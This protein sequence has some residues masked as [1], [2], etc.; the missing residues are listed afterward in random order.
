MKKH[1]KILSFLFLTLLV[2]IVCI[3]RSYPIAKTEVKQESLALNLSTN[4]VNYV[5]SLAV[6]I[7]FSDSS[8]NTHHLDDEQSVENAYKIFNSDELFEMNSVNGIIKVPSFKKYYEKESYGNLIITTEIFP[9]ENGKVVSY[10]D[11]HPIGYYLEYNEANKIGYKD[12][13]ESL[14]RETELIN[15][16]TNYIATMVAS[17]SIKSA[18]LDIDNDGF[19]DAIS[20]IIEGQKNLPSAIKWRDLLWSHERD[21]AG[22]EASI[23]GKKVKSYT[24]LYANDYT[25]SASL[26]SLNR[27]TY[28]TIIHEFGH[29]LGY[30]DLYRYGNDTAKPVGFYDIMGTTVGSNPQHFLTYY[31]SE[32]NPATNWH[33]PLPVIKETTNNITLYKPTFTDKTEK[34]AIKIQIDGIN[35]EYFVVEYHEKQNTY[36][37]HSADKSG[38]IVYRVNEKYKYYG[39]TDGSNSGAKDH[40]YIFRPNE[41]GLGDGKGDLREATLNMS[42]KTF[43][44]ELDLNNLTFDN[45]AIFFS[46]GTNSGI[47]IEVISE[48]SNSVTFNVEFPK[49][50]GSGT[51][52][53][54]YLIEDANTFMY[55]MKLSTKN[56]YYKLMKDIDFN[57]IENYPTINFEGNLEGN[58]KTLR[59]IKASN[60]VFKT[61]GYY[62]T[63]TTI[64]NLNIENIVIE[65]KQGDYLGGLAA[66]AENVTLNNV[67][68]KSGTIKQLGTL[69]HDMASTGGF[70]GNVNN[71]TIIKNCSAIADINAPK[72]IGGFIGLNMNAKIENS[73]ASSTINGTA[74]IGGFIGV[75]AIL[76]NKYNVPNN[77][78]YKAN[79]S[80]TLN[81]VG[82]Y[83]N[84][85]HN[86]NVLNE[87]SLA[88]GII[89][90]YLPERI[91]LATTEK[92]DIPFKTNPDTSLNYTAT[93]KD[94]NIARFENN[95]IIGVNKGNTD[96]YI[97][98]KIGA[99]MMQ[100]TSNLIV[101]DINKA[102]TEAEVL[103]ALGLNKKEQYVFGFNPG[104]SL[105]DINSKIKNI[106][107]VEL[108]GFTNENGVAIISGIAKTGIKLSL[109]INGT[110]YTYTIVILGDINGDGMIYATDYVKVKNHIMGKGTLTGAYLLA[111]DINKD[112]KIYATD[113]VQ[114]KNHIMGKTII[115]QQ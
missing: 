97:N 92:K 80:D 7:K 30:M 36:E 107:N 33:S 40:V 37:T 114:I 32:Y 3:Q 60:G 34:R 23:L 69:L 112:G 99:S 76:D 26:F 44:K 79:S 12:A 51:K 20:F 81:A 57:N 55:L 74:N 86:L 71:T 102:L 38:I 108:K 47:K 31:I 4:K 50:A 66:V 27:G 52:A 94:T 77:V 88:T 25:E 53:D 96:I 106:S 87:A 2:T 48:T 61:I 39:S 67:H 93:I 19:I 16:A 29:V 101:D 83:S 10:T 45:D 85:F 95:K 65:S 35:D 43:G 58:N 14:K 100:L 54:P 104:T 6:F 72:N 70:I 28:G 5:K 73:F 75:Q 17:S 41:T 13:Q 63:S 90:I 42:R 89:K 103:G 115:K 18:D 21:N 46:D 49:T 22:A 105:Q 1:K 110:T 82:G 78:Y 11:S 98:I 113:Y 62:E 64:E 111:A 59:N 8:V 56:K 68:I 91:N 15:A 109:Y 24:L 84:Y 9:Q